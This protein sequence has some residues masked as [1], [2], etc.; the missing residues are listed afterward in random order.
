MGQCTYKMCLALS[1]P[2][3]NHSSRH[4][5]GCIT[6]YDQHPSLDVWWIRI[7][8]SDR[9]PAIFIFSKSL[10]APP[11]LFWETELSVSL[12]FWLFSAINSFFWVRWLWN[13]TVFQHSSHQ[14]AADSWRVGGIPIKGHCPPRPPP[15]E[16]TPECFFW[17]DRCQ[18]HGGVCVGGPSNARQSRGF[19]A[20]TGASLSV[21]GRCCC[22]EN[23]SLCWCRECCE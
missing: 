14:A 2:W 1:Q 21:K 16:I 20:A 15:C 17:A 5:D 13:C 9:W 22:S 7:H 3:A 8:S 6:C 4:W 10:Q 12:T 23:L 11:H 18:S 19:T